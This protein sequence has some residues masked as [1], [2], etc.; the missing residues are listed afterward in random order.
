[1]SEMT[2]FFEG[3]GMPYQTKARLARKFAAAIGYRMSKVPKVRDWWRLDR[4]GEPDPARYRSVQCG[5]DMVF[6][7][8]ATG[9]RKPA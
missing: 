2:G 4:I 1:M 9:M 8:L 6:A 7:F 3:L 5:L